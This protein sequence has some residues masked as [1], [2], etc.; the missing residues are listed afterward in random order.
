MEKRNSKFEVDRPTET[1]AHE[2][3][4]SGLWLSL[5]SQA[6]KPPTDVY[7]TDEAIV[8]RLEIAGMREE[9]FSVEL[10]GRELIIHGLRQDTDERRAFH[11]MEIRFGEFNQSV[12]LPFYILT[13]QIRAD[14]NNGLLRITLPK[15]PPRQIPL[16]E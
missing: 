10:K 3:T 13:E 15:A 9:D 1:E 8:V 14:Y 6:W 16:T 2:S 7:E 4:L 12:E 5:R 11:Q